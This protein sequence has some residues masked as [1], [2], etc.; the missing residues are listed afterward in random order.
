[1]DKKK[2]LMMGAALVTLSPLAVRDAC[3]VSANG[4]MKA[5]I[6]QPI[7]LNVTKSLYFGQATA[8]TGGTIKMDTADTRSATGA[9]N[10]MGATGQSGV[11]KVGAAAGFAIDLS[12][13]ATKFTVN[14]AATPTKTMVV[15]NFNLKTNAGGPAETITLVGATMKVPVGAT[16]NVANAQAAGVYKGTFTVKA[17]YQ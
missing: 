17:T 7:T 11:I 13:T 4:Q 3:A 15:D 16:L 8:G 5:T 6:I 14:I 9:V 2:L 10:L 1:M 12:V